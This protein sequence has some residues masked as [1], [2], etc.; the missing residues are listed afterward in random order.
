MITYEEVREMFD[1]DPITG[2]LSWKKT[3]KGRKRTVAGCLDGK[4]H[5]T[6]HLRPRSYQ[7]HRIIWLWQTG[8]WPNGTVDHKN[9]IGT[10]NR[11]CNLRVANQT[12]QNANQTVRRT[13]TSGYKGV[14]WHK[15]CKRY[16]AVIHVKGKKLWLGLHDTPEVAAAAYL[17]AAKKHFGEF[18][19]LK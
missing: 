8:E 11:W 1:Y 5:Y 9:R 13:N 16:A 18:A 4:G 14:F 7:L 2:I 12:Q 17:E 10:D 19:R 3:G 15:E 6:I